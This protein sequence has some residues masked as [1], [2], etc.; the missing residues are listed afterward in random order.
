M[1]S[2]ICVV[3]CVP[4][5]YFRIVQSSVITFSIPLNYKVS[6]RNFRQICDPIYLHAYLVPITCPWLHQSQSHKTHKSATRNA[7]P[8]CNNQ[9]PPLLLYPPI[10]FFPPAT[11]QDVD[12]MYEVRSDVPPIYRVVIAPSPPKPDHGNQSRVA[13]ESVRCVLRLRFGPDS[14]N[15]VKG[16]QL[17]DF[18]IHN[19]QFRNSQ[20]CLL[21]QDNY[22]LRYY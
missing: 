20:S 12:T 2:S 1:F 22:Y 6:R 17:N 15:E 5:S 9:T 11:S 18:T 14:A 16:Q 3:R 19:S 8:I 13:L 4:K 10:L 21:L 7:Q